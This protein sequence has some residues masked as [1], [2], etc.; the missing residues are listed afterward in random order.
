MNKPPKLVWIILS[1]SVLTTFV[2]NAC[3][4]FSMSGLVSRLSITLWLALSAVLFLISVCGGW[5]VL[6]KKWAAQT[7][8]WGERVLVALMAVLGLLVGGGGICLFLAIM[9]DVQK[10]RAML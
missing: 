9:L 5:S 1:L 4:T 8:R 6:P 7:R 2:G 3:F 10:I